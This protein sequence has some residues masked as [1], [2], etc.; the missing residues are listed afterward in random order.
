MLLAG[1]KDA[2]RSL[3]PASS[4]SSC[5]VARFLLCLDSRA[6]GLGFFFYSFVVWF[7]LC[8][9]AC[10]LFVSCS[11]NNR[12][13]LR[14]A[15]GREI[16]RDQARRQIDA[17]VL[18]LYSGCPV[19]IERR[20]SLPRS[21]ACKGETLACERGGQK[22]SAIQRPLRS[23]ELVDQREASREGGLVDA[24][25]HSIARSVASRRGLGSRWVLSLFCAC[26]PA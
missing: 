20:R 24:C 15:R 1:K 12:R 13:P 6:M 5:L 7:V 25:G 2:E 8:V 26:L 10:V 17:R 3:S 14:R 21:S 22:K 19:L 4:R 11:S 23:G 18:S 9:R 16:K